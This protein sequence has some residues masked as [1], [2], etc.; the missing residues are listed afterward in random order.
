MNGARCGG[1]GRCATCRG[2]ENRGIARTAV[3]R[4]GH[5]SLL[6]SKDFDVDVEISA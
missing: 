4:A 1:T 5:G 3:T 2:E 6:R